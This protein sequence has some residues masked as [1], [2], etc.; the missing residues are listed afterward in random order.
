MVQ[1]P[2]ILATCPH[3]FEAISA[4]ASSFKLKKIRGRSVCS[5]VRRA[6]E[7]PSTER[8]DEIDWDVNRPGFW[9]GSMIWEHGVHGTIEKVRGVSCRDT[10]PERGRL[11]RIRGPLTARVICR[12]HTRPGRSVRPRTTSGNSLSATPQRPDEPGGGNDGASQFEDAMTADD[13]R[14]EL[15]AQLADAQHPAEVHVDIN[16]GELHRRVGGYPGRNHR[17]RLCCHVLRREMAG[18]EQCPTRPVDI[19]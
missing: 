10:P 6:S 9:R 17:M 15:R 2:L 11:G 14:R 8:M 16:A 12:R 18:E 4:L 13:F 7:L 1:E 5:S 3:S 19:R